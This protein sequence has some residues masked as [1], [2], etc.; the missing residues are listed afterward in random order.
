[1]EIQA[2]MNGIQSALYVGGGDTLANFMGGVLY[3]NLGGQ[4]M[5]LY[6]SYVFMVWTAVV[7]VQVMMGRCRGKRLG[8]VTKQYSVLKQ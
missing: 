2:T 5:F 8:R 1:M 7:A 4:Q 6:C 3:E